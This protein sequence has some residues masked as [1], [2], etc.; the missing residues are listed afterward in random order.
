MGAEAWSAGQAQDAT[1][2]TSCLW[3]V[4]P[5]TAGGETPD[6]PGSIQVGAGWWTG[7]GYLCAMPD[8]TRKADPVVSAVPGH[9]GQPVHRVGLRHDRLDALRGLALLWM[10]GFHAAFDLNLHRLI[11]Q[12][13]FYE[14]P[15]WTL[16]RVGILSLFLVCAGAGQV[17]AQVQQVPW[18]RF[19]RR[20]W[21]LVGA[22]A[23]VSLSS[24]WMFPR[25]W[26]SFG[27]L[28]A[29]AL[30][31]LLARGL[32]GRPPWVWAVLATV[33]LLAP[34]LGSAPFFDSRWTNWVGLVTHK[35]VTEDYVPL[36]PWFAVLLA[37][38][39]GQRWLALHRSEWSEAALSPRW[40]PLVRLG[41]WSLPY[42]LLHQP[43]LLGLILVWQQIRP[44]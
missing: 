40:Q 4:G 18:A 42:Y 7:F 21:L 16:Q 27:V 17:I 3:L 25:S 10:T 23:L 8:P 44:A 28:H 35:P 29:L 15:L 33:C 41:R 6:D 20:W 14:D 24:W 31:T 11:P 36:L 13:N 32:A 22:A 30:M 2:V 34:M 39:G 12:Q 26:I 38:M 1:H 43:V 19:W 5:R 37:G 9:P